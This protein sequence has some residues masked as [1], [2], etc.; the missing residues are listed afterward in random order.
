MSD[1]ANEGHCLFLNA[2]NVTDSGFSFGECQFVSQ[3]KDDGL[4]K[5]KL[6]RNDVV[7]TTR[8][9]LGN[10][11]W[12]AGNIPFDN[13]RINSGMVILRADPARL[14]PAYLYVFLRSSLFLTQV[15]QLRSGAAQPQLPIRDLIRIKLPIPP[16]PVQ[17]LIASNVTPYDELVENNQ[18]R[19]ALLEDAARQLYQEWF[20]RL[21]FPGSQHTLINNKIPDGW[22][23]LP[24][25]KIVGAATWF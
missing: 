11:A 23:R 14:N 21:R 1:F 3:E 4:R 9:T 20:V 2:K 7:L 16:K 8:G 15:T 24:L 6:R 18:R 25:E 5:G 22:E 12:Y 17:D 10:V 13:V 19:M